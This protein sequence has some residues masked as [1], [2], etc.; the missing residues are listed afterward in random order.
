ML[1]YQRYFNCY[2]FVFLCSG[3]YITN[4]RSTIR[5]LYTRRSTFSGIRVARASPRINHL[6]FA[7]DT[8]FFCKASPRSCDAL[9]TIPMKYE[10]PSGKVINPAKSFVTFAKKTPADVKTRVKLCLGI[11]REGGV[12]KY[13]GLPEHFGRRKKDLFTSIVDRIRQKA[14]SWATKK[15][16]GAGKLVLLKNVLSAIPTHAIPVLNSP[17]VSVRGFNPFLLGSCGIQTRGIGRF[18]GSHGHNLP[19]RNAMEGW[20]C[21]TFKT[22]MM[23]S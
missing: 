12:E 8:M 14:V 2:R 13:L 7:D 6:P 20:V 23:P 4:S 1:N 17:L 9:M 16:S 15:L 3:S 21:V 11:D 18:A 5:R 19:C 10:Q 22:L